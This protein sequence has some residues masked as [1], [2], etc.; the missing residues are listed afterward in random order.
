M[1]MSSH[2]EWRDIEIVNGIYSVSNQGRVKNNRTGYI[3]KP[4]KFTKGYVKVNLKVGG[5]SQNCLVHRLVAMAFIENPENKAEVNHKNGIHDDNRLENLE[6]VTGEENKRHAYETGLVPHKDMQRTGYLYNLWHTRK[7]RTHNWSAEW[8][9]FLVFQQWCLNNGYV[10][11]DYIALIDSA[12][13]YLPNNCYISKTKV[14][15]SK[16]YECLGELLNYK[17]IEEKYGLTEGCIKYRM[18]KG[19]SLEEAVMTPKGKAKD[20]S[21]RIRLSEQQYRHIFEEAQK[22]NETTSAYIRELIDRDI[23]EKRN[24]VT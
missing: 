23:S 7:S 24:G 5:R 1:R 2:E 21:L 17:E 13:G 11:G 12:K 14:H 22:S 3:L 10:E 4:V 6:W 18:H 9:D 20:N 19:M 8:D 15:P 16:K